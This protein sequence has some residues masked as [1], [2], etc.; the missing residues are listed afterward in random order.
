MALV[1]AVFHVPGYAF[2]VIA[3]AV[4]KALAYVSA[5]G[6]KFPFSF[7]GEAVAVCADIVLKAFRV[8][9][10]IAFC[11]AEAVAVFDCV[12]PRYVLY[13][14]VLSLVLAGVLFHDALVFFLGYFVGADIEF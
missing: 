13:G 5:A 6:R 7:G 2:C 12:V 10:G 8:A 1:S 9:G 11:Q 3:S 4:C 14:Q